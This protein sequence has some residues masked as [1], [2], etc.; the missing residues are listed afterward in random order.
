MVRPKFKEGDLLII[1]NTRRPR[2]HIANII[3]IQW[4]VKVPNGKDKPKNKSMY[5]LKYYDSF[6]KEHRLTN[7]TIEQIDRICR[8][9]TTTEIA[10][11]A[12][13]I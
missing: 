6:L 8:K 10:L 5:R 4:I 13:K 1:E 12:P 2:Y 7:S 3:E 9:M 11:Y